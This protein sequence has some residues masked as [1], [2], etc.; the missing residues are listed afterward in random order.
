MVNLTAAYTAPVNPPNTTPVLSR[1]TVFAGLRKK[2][3]RAQDFVPVIISCD[4]VSVE[5]NVVTRDIVFKEG[6]GPP[7]TVREVCVEFEPTKVRI[8]SACDCMMR[9]W[10]C[11]DKIENTSLTT[12]F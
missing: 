2:V 7:G 3:R 1:T 5:D 4:V 6:E 12:K 10:M 11:E 9:R 8:L